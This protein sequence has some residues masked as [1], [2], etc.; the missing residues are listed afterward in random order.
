MKALIDSTERDT[1]RPEAPRI[2]TGRFDALE[3]LA[4]VRA[5]WMQVLI[6]CSVAVLLAVIGSLVL[7]K[8][9]TA[10]ASLVIEPPAGND[11][12]GATAV[13]LVYLE[14]LKTYEHF[15]TSDTLFARALEHLHLKEKYSGTDLDS[16][17]RR[18]LKVSKP[19]NTKI[20][21]IS[22]TLR[23][24]QKAQALVQYL[25]EQTRGLNQTLDEESGEEVTK[26]SRRLLAQAVTRL[27]NAQKARD[28]FT[29]TQ[30]VE[31]LGEEVGNASE[32]KFRVERDLGRAKAEL[33]DLSAQQQSFQPGAQQQTDEEW[34]GR[35]VAATRARI[36]D[37]EEQDRKLLDFVTAKGGVLEQL[38]QRRES[39]DIELRAARAD[40]EAAKTKLSDIQTSAAF[41]GERIKLLDP[42]IV[43][44][45]PSF[46][47]MALN[48]AVALGVCLIA[49][50]VYLA[51]G[52]AHLRLRSLQRER[53]Y[54][55]R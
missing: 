24:P 15:A 27:Q 12:R 45:Q 37:L 50:A 47:N 16:L 20:I 48:V 46:P 54:G 21:E 44:D 52:F 28:E 43:P 6:A 29:R 13:S 23:D 55:L 26:Q 38:R 39:L 42:G 35:Q 32:L 3:F 5:K 17:K 19:L 18:I 11:P 8:R 22:A 2:S 33:A 34:V 49:S 1:S 30:A 14:S 40:Y 7:P 41:R 36:K 9:Y 51:F 10:T 4:Y 25:A 53:A 31:N